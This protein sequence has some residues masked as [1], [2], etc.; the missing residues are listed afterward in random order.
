MAASHVLY[1]NLW[2]PLHPHPLSGLIL[3]TLVIIL[4]FN[5]VILLLVRRRAWPLHPP[6]LSPRTSACEET[7]PKNWKTGAVRERRLRLGGTAR[8]RKGWVVQRERGRWSAR[9]RQG[10]FA[11]AREGWVGEREREREREGWGWFSREK[12]LGLVSEREEAGLA[13][14]RGEAG[15]GGSQRTARRSP[16][17]FTLLTARTLHLPTS[18]Q[19]HTQRIQLSLTTHPTLSLAHTS[20]PTLSHTPRLT[21]TEAGPFGIFSGAAGGGA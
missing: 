14:E 11:R 19:S 9:E 7:S 6:A 16:A 3:I 8:E 4:L 13:S 20:H 18:N 12:R 21:Y 15:P 2:P 1:P 17:P 10:W 5:L